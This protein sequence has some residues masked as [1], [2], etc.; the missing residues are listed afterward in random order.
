MDVTRPVRRRRSCRS[1]LVAVILLQTSRAARPGRADRR[2]RADAADRPAA[3]AAAAPRQPTHRELMGDLSNTA[4]DIV[5]RPAGAARHRRRAGLPRPLPRASR[6]QVRRAGVAVA[7]RRSRCSTRCRSC[8][9]ASSWWSS[10]GSAPGTPSPGEISA[11]RAGRVLRLR[12]V[13]DDPAAHRHRVRQQADP[14]PRRRPPGRAGCSRST[15][16][17]RRRRPRA[18]AARRRRPLYDARTGLHVAP[19]LLTAIVSE[20]PDDVGGAGRPARPAPARPTTRSGSAA[21]R[22]TRLP[23]RRGARA[24][25][26]SSDTGATLFTGRLRDRLD[27][28]RRRRG[29]DG[30]APCTPPAPRTSSTR[31]PDGLDGE[32][33]E[34]GRAFSGGQRQRLVLARALLADP[35]VLVLVEPTSAVDA[36]TEARIAARLR[37]APGRPDHRGHHHQPADARPGRHGRLPRDGR[38]VAAGTH[39]EL[40]DTA[41][42]Y[43]ADRRPARTEMEHGGADED[44]PARSPAAPRSARYAAAHSRRRH[45]RTVCVDAGPARARPRWPALA[46]PRLLGDLVEAVA[47]RHHASATSTG[48][49]LVLAGVRGGADGA[50]PVRRATSRRRSASRCWPSCART[51]STNTLALP[52]RHR[53][54]AGTGDLLTRTSRDVDAARL[55]GALG[56]AGVD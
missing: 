54:A 38:V 46:A 11:G 24:G 56:G 36:H 25:S 53:R 6:R 5:S 4:S 13:P 45:P 49:S 43:R 51:S 15:R 50:D 3:R 30:R 1:S 14:R 39:R 35:E 27:D 18:V 8:C 9:P 12:R 41:P 2:A 26:W 28:P 42:S 23:P 22:S 32:V 17:P 20:Q 34:Q 21:C 29:R 40:L 10:S 7:R 44:R 16:A 19:G 55:V 48:S 52:R 31:S 37:A 33:A 47:G